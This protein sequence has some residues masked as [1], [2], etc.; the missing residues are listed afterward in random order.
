MSTAELS[1][2]PRPAERRPAPAVAW[3]RLLR[4]ELRLIFLRWRNLILLA[5]L[6]AIPVLIGVALRLAGAGSGGQG[7]PFLNQVAGNGVFLAFLALTVMLTLVLPLAV[8]VVSG[9]SVAGE[10]G[11]GTLRYLLTVPV[12]RTRLLGIKYTGLLCYCLVA[13]LLIAL[14]SLAVGAAAFP[15]GPVTLLSGSSVSL[16]DG[17]LRLLLV[18]LYVAAGMGALAAIGLAVSTFTEH[19][20]AAIAAILVIT[21]GSEVADNVPQFSAVHPFLPTHW[22]LSFDGLLRSPVAWGEIGQGLAS[23]AIYAVIFA[24]IAWARFT[25]ADVTS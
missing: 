5:V 23:F 1:A 12:G 6:A 21:I 11:H 4:S 15:V 16:G 18:T 8:A 2:P 10:A 17:L 24:V 7:P 19:A 20:I 14:V 3:L 22:W 13:C 25:T 9:D